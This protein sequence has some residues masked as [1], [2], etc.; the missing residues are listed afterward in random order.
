MRINGHA[1]IFN[2]QTVLTSEAIGIILARLE[3]NKYPGFVVEG[4]RTFLLA[5][6]E[7][8]EYLTEDGLLRRFLAAIADN[9]QF[10][11]FLA[12]Q[13]ARLPVD[14][15]LL[16]QTPEALASA[17]LRAAL[18]HL[19][20]HLDPR[21]GL[22]RGIFDLFE[23]LR[24]A[25]QPDVVSVADALLGQLP[26]DTGLIALMMDI[27]ATPEPPR[28]LKN[29]QAQLRG[30]SEA[31]LARPGRIFPFVA[32]NPN[33]PDH[34]AVMRRAIEQTG[35]VGVKLY[36]SL[37]YE[38]TSRQMDAVLQY[39]DDE[40]VPIVVHTTAGG[41][42]K[43]PETAQ[44]CNPHA[45][46]ELLRARPSLR[47]S[48]AHCGGWGGLSGQDPLQVPWWKDV[49]TLM[50]THDNVY[51]DLS[52][53]VEMRNAPAKEAAYFGALKALLADPR[54]ADRLI[55]GTDS[56]LV[57]LS[58]AEEPYW[59]YF[60]EHLGD[61]QL[62]AI[63]ETAPSRFLGLPVDGAPPRRNIERH[64]AWLEAR[65]NQVGAEPAPW[66]AGLSGAR[67]SPTR[68][69]PR[70]SPNNRA[71]VHLFQ[72]LRFE[73]KQI[74]K[75]F[76][77]LGFDGAGRV[78]LRQLGYFTRDHEPAALFE[79]RC[80]ENAVNLDAF[81]RNAGAAYEGDHGRESAVGQ[82]KG[83]FIDGD[84]TLAEAAAAVD[85]IYLFVTEV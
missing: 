32:V 13:G 7:R 41:F 34:F 23:T 31:A 10:R 78:R 45:W 60:M 25:M 73:V 44:F 85:A 24:L 63:M 61:D 54:T 80:K 16:G 26:D 62:R 56:W 3:R 76:H 33:R 14:V 38:V 11:A 72:F 79:N 70:W 53:H 1:H 64:V 28:D 17:T 83:M 51:G 29:F 12:E 58:I 49:L 75:D 71:H 82:L 47:V 68:A 59:R 30:T 84:R 55:F 52:Y 27:V 81:L 37:G 43:S 18:D 6:L 4:L 36:P 50:Q 21:D 48:F 20:T 8:P 77:P 74:P 67:F 66:V 46:I 39:C 65:A 57:R 40:D 15:R 5:Q 9:D 35:F 42:F 19:S 2:L 22:G 69:N